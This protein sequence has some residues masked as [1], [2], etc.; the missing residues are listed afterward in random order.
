M[1]A[2]DFVIKMVAGA[3]GIPQFHLS[4][5]P[6]DS[7]PEAVLETAIIISL[8]TDRLA[9]E[10]DVIPDGTNDR[11]GYWGDGLSLI[12]ADKIGSRLWLLSREKQLTNVLRRAEE[13]ADEALSWLL[14]DGVAKAVMVTATNPRDG[15]LNLDI[16]IVNP[17]ST[18]LRFS[19]IWRALNG[20]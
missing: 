4:L 12:N 6:V 8:F 3:D 16:D 7:T 1:S 20:V 5:D 11:R 17:D 10:D 19:Y 18:T 15:W 13:Y 14:D 9:D 2:N